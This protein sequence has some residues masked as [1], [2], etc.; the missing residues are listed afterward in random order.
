MACLITKLTQ[1]DCANGTGY[2]KE[3]VN[4]VIPW[5][6]QKTNR[7]F[8]CLWIPTSRGTLVSRWIQR[9]HMMVTG[10]K[11]YH[12]GWGNKEELLHWKRRQIK[13]N[14]RAVQVGP[15]AST[16]T[17]PTN[18]KGLH[19]V[20]MPSGSWLQAPPQPQPPALH[21]LCTPVLLWRCLHCPDTIMS[22]SSFLLVLFFKHQNHLCLPLSW[23]NFSSLK[24]SS[25]WFTPENFVTLS[26]LFYLPASSKIPP[27]L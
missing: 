15:C 26:S 25:Y 1:R 6:G 12:R 14:R 8:S 23:Y 9:M 16:D 5:F 21:F 19:P 3:N 24:L 7:I 10:L 22:P 27:P 20:L 17:S 11:I 13:E 4:L 2:A 18:I